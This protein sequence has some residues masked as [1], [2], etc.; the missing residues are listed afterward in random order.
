[1]SEETGIVTL[2]SVKSELLGLG[3][4]VP[5]DKILDALQH[6][7]IVLDRAKNMKEFLDA[8]MLEWIVENHADIVVGEIRYYAGKSKSVKCQDVRGAIEAI[9]EVSGGDFVKLCEVLSSNA[10]KPGAAKTVL[11]DSFDKFFAT[12]WDDKLE[13]GTPVKTLKTFNPAFSK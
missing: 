8:A 9:L 2:D 7:K 12:V 3:A 13:E 5:M 1:M 10:L 6:V 4:K 11:G